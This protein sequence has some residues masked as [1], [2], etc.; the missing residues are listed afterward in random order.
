MTTSVA[1]VGLGRM[2]SGI[3]HNIQA[4]G[5]RFIVYN[6]TLKKMQPFLASGATAASSPREA[7][8]E[9]D[10]VVTSLMDDSSVLDNV[11]GQ[12]GILA[13][14]RPDAVHIGATTVSPR[15]STR[16]AELHAAQGSHYVAA[17]VAGRPDAA[18]AGKLITFVAGNPEVIERCRP[19]LAAYASQIILVGDDPALAASMKLLGNFFVASLLELMG[20]AFVFAEKRGLNLDVFSGMLKAALPHPGTQEYAE[21]IRTR[22]FD[23]AGFTLDGG[24]KDV[25]LILDAAAEVHVPLPYANVIRDHCIIAQAHGMSQRDWSCFTEATRLEAG[26]E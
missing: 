24:L 8:T 12:D 6:R 25:R 17:P 11:M 23:D 21:R 13:G 26:Q 2:G 9:A 1:C 14:M 16:L 10:V 15:L 4:A 19:V 7:A 3:A 22:R 20:Q 5:F 18:A